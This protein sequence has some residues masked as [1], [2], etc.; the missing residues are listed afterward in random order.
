MTDSDPHHDNESAPSGVHAPPHFMRCLTPKMPEG[1]NA[2]DPSPTFVFDRDGRCRATIDDERRP[3]Q[4]SR[5]TSSQWG[6]VIMFAVLAV[7]FGAGVFVLTRSLLAA[8]VAMVAGLLSLPIL[9]ITHGTPLST[10]TLHPRNAVGATF[11]PRAD[12]VRCDG[13]AVERPLSSLYAVHVLEG[14]VEAGSCFLWQITLIFKQG[15]AFER[16]LMHTGYGELTDTHRARLARVGVVAGVPMQFFRVRG[17]R[18]PVSDICLDQPK[19]GR[20]RRVDPALA[21]AAAVEP[22]GPTWDA[23][24][25]DRFDAV[26]VPLPPVRATMTCLKCRY[27]L[28]GLT[29]D[30]VCPECG[31]PIRVVRAGASAMQE[32]AT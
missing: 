21:R 18:T 10:F 2:T 30:A 28:V 9:A 5:L 15:D 4:R 16:V 29:G 27:E 20:I 31:E 8:F 6:V 26:T 13:A 19:L 17:W 11:D 32:Q 25:R 7:V 14:A 1:N 23:L 24:G 22:L 3:V 12:L